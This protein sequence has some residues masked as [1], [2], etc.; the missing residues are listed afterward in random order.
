M[1]LADL[2]RNVSG[3]SF[4]RLVYNRDRYYIN[5]LSSV[6]RQPGISNAS[7]ARAAFVTAQSMQGIVANLETMGLLRRERDP[8]H[9]RI[10]ESQ[11]T[12]AGA[13]ALAGAGEAIAGVADRMTAGF[14]Q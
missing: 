10:M 6:G 2:P 8:H 5:V 3:V 14:R 4:T 7:L 11:L 13:K 12:E 1:I 9:G